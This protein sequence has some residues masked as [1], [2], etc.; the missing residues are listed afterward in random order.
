M[1]TQREDYYF[2]NFQGQCL[3]PN[4]EEVKSSDLSNSPFILIP[5]NNIC[6]HLSE[7]NFSSQDKLKKAKVSNFLNYCQ[8]SNIT[9]LPA[10]GLMERASKPG[11]LELNKDKLT[12]SEDLFWRTLGHYSNND[13]ISSVISTIEPLKA[14]LYPF[15]AYLLK[16]KLILIE[17]EPSHINLKANLQDLHDFTDEIGISLAL[18]W[19]FAVAIF[20]GHTELNRFIRPKKGDSFKALWGAAWDLFYI[21]LIHQYSGVREQIEGYFPGYILVTDDKACF[22][23]GDF[24]KV[25]FG[26]DYGDTIY[27]GVM[28]NSNF[29]H[30][31]KDSNILSEITLKMYLDMSQRSIV[32]A[33][34]SELDRQNN[35]E[36]VIDRAH[37]FILETTQRIQLKEKKGFG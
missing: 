23:I 6:I 24:A 28:M 29:P 16:I 25:T 17:R 19:Q 1:S 8:T 37:S 32:R 10:Y 18:P 3:P 22:T 2:L 35:I 7:N 26:F 15:Y 9:V 4:H 13:R 31:K 33:S 27:N 34:M 36:Q 30:L 14:F 21:Q 5:D 20:G 11:S 12:Y